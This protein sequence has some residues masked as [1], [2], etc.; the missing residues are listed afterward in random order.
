[1]KQD[2][3]SITVVVDRSGS[4]Q[5]V[6]DEAQKGINAFITEQA[7]LPGDALFTLVQFD[8]EHETLCDGIPIKDVPPYTLVPRG[9]TALLDA[10]GRAINVTAARLEGM[11]KKERPGKVAVVIVTDGHEN[12]SHEFTK[13]QINALITSKQADGWKFTFLGADAQAFDDAKSMGIQAANTV[14]YDSAKAG[15]TLTVASESLASYRSGETGNLSYTAHM[16][17]AVRK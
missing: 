5:T 13:E 6:R 2:M 3:T 15:E 9:M 1:M 16:R 14:Q 10:I 7:A 12:S 4:M 8:T 17:R 11:K